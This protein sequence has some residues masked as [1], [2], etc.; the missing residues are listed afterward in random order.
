MSGCRN[1]CYGGSQVRE[2]EKILIY[3]CF[4]ALVGG[5]GMVKLPMSDYVRDYYKDQGITFTFRQQ[6]CLCWNYYPL[7]KDRLKS[8]KDIL[9]ISDDEKLN[10]EIKER[11]EYEEKAF[12]CFMKNN[13]PSVL[14]IFHSDDKEAYCDEYFASAK[15][16]IS[17]GTHHCNKEFSI[18][19]RYF[20]DRCPDTLS[21]EKDEDEINT[22]LAVYDFTS[23]GNVLYGSSYECTAPFDQEDSS[24]FEEMFLN[25]KSPFGLGDIVMAPDFESPRVV[26]TDHDCFEKY[27][28]R[29]KH[30]EI[31][32]PDIIDNSIRT[33]WIGTDGNPYYD[34]TVP[35]DLWKIDS[36]EDENYWEILQILSRCAKTEVSIFDLDYYIDKY[37]KT[38]EKE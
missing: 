14:Y 7:L 33:D 35:F 20:L 5:E 24:R 16:A 22:L 26:T 32:N 2:K 36:W 34:H 23:G 12:E 10:N 8:L 38:C 4:P 18:D 30:S 13:D 17:Y 19:K 3:D 31:L 6:A 37:K 1:S 25:I 21:N 28:E 9:S 27:Y 15:A 29:A 11:V